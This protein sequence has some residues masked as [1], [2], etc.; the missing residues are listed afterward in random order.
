MAAKAPNVH[1]ELLTILDTDVISME[2][3]RAM[4]RSTGMSEEKF[5]QEFM[6]SFKAGLENA[7]YAELMRMMEKEHRITRVPYDPR[8]PVDTSWDLGMDDINSIWFWQCMPNGVLHAIDYYE[9]RNKGMDFYFKI[10][11]ERPYLYRYHVGPHDLSVREFSSG[12]PRW[13]FAK[14]H[15]FPFMYESNKKG[16]VADGIAAVRAMLPRC[17]IDADKC[18]KGINALKSYTAEEVEEK[19][20]LHNK[21]DHNWA[22]NAADSIRYFAMQVNKI[23]KKSL[24]RTSN[25][26]IEAIHNYDVFG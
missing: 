25:Q 13:K 9:N 1:C 10:L 22:S 18:N 3:A 12:V 15:G 19:H 11:R 21:P 17:Y 16:S 7:Y 8:Y 6:C 20:T 14:E 24:I 2:D 4:Q 5:Q 26:V 23:Y